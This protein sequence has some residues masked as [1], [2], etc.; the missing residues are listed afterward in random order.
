VTGAEAGEGA[1]GLDRLLEVIYRDYHHDFRSYARASLARGVARARLALGSVTLTDMCE[2]V[3][4]DPT[5]FATLLAELTVPVSELFRDPPY[6]RVLR[7]RIIPHLATYPS[8]RVWVAGCGAGE[9]AYSIAV[10]LEE[11]GLLH[12][13]LIYATDIDGA[14]LQVASSGVYDPSRTSGLDE[15]YRQAGGR[16]SMAECSTA[17]DK[18]L[19]FDPRLRE[20]ILF[21]EHS[22]ATDAAFAEVQL[23]S[24]RNVFIYFDQ[25][26]QDRA[27]GLFGESLCPRGFLGLGGSET[28]D[29]SAHQDSFEPFALRERVYR[30]TR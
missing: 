20:R 1:D 24:C 14:A 3:A 28:L 16:G 21:S 10:L 9:E 18:H 15:R 27:V 23:V 11:A 5:A 30:R 19:A 2:L 13:S 4:D 6:F 26:L 12:R 22:L 29:S 17:S 25:D 8:P 7:E